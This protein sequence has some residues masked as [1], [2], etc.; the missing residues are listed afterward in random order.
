[1]VAVGRPRPTPIRPVAAS[2][3]ERPEEWPQSQ[4]E[5]RHRM[6]TA[7]RREED[8]QT[9]KQRSYNQL[10]KQTT[11]P[12]AHISFRRPT[13]NKTLFFSLTVFNAPLSLSGENTDNCPI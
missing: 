12:I 9:K 3:E 8:S 6:G 11:D 4:S 2:L 13:N 5:P 10:H 7:L 1:M